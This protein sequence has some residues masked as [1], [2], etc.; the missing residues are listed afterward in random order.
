MITRSLTRRRRARTVR[1]L[2]LRVLHERLP[3]DLVDLIAERLWPSTFRLGPRTRASWR[4][5]GRSP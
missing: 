2:I 5:E 3:T 4:A 1:R